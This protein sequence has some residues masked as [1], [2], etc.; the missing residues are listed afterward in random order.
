MRHEVIPSIIR[1]IF[2]VIFDSM[3]LG[4]G[5]L[6]DHTLIVLSQAAWLLA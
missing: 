5:P 4:C 6:N 1:I 3:H 2:K